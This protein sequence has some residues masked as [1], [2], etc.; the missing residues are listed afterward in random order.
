MLEVRDLTSGYGDGIVLHGASFDVEAGEVV[1]L[2]GRNGVG[3]TTLIKTIMGLLPPQEGL[4]RFDG[5]DIAGMRPFEIA[6]R[7]LAY[8]PQGREIF[9][10]F[11]VEENLILGDLSR[12]DLTPAYDVFPVLRERRKQKGGTLSGGQQQQ[13]AIARALISDPRMILLDEPS[14]GIQPNI[15]EDIGAVLKDIARDRGVAI[16]VVEQNIDL[17][18][19]LAERCL[20]MDGGAIIDAAAVADLQHDRARIERHLSL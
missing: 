7:G 2:L 15:V 16:L 10:D 11:T 13:L 18:F 4:I 9:S 8:V 5:H 12:T 17:V 3:K 1:A 19:G 14:E 6:G 20:F